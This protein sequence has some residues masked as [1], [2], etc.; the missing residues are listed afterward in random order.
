MNAD[1]AFQIGAS[2]SICQDYSVAGGWKARTEKAGQARP[3][4]IISDGCS[5][6]ADTDIGARLLTKAVEE[7]FK[8]CNSDLRDVAGI[9]KAAARRA[10]TW[11]KLLGLSPQAVDATLITA[12]VVDEQLLIGCSGDGVICLERNDERTDVYDI[13][14]PSGYPL[15]P[16]YTHQSERLLTLR[17][18]GHTIRRTDL[19]ASTSDSDQLRIEDSYS[20]DS[21]TEVFV[22]KAA[23]YKFATVF[24]DGIH[25]FVSTR[26]SPTGPKC[27]AISMQEVLGGLSSFKNTRGAFVGRRM[28]MF[29]KECQGKGWQHGDDLAVGAIHLGD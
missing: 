21:L 8:N 11:A 19:Y 18:S 4:V 5:A 23:D 1:T 20:S 27:S 22:F 15:Y 7:S 12:H 25:S 29:R 16:T 2:H 14:Y 17:D 13:S 24:S 28:K 9:H 6:S 3:Y 10:L 26:P